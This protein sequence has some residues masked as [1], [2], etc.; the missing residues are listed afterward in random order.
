MA[1]SSHRSCGLEHVVDDRE[2]TDSDT[3]G[4]Q[5]S[6]ASDARWWHMSCACEA[7]FSK[8]VELSC[9]N[10]FSIWAWRA[11]RDLFQIDLTYL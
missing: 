2:A 1:M 7:L 3:T 9:I 11:A 6:V 8:C 10:Q 5:T 4:K